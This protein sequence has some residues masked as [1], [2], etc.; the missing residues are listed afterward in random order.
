MLSPFEE[1]TR[2][3]CATH[4]S[5]MASGRCAG[6]AVRPRPRQSTMLLLHEHMGGHEPDA[7]LHGCTKALPPWPGHTQ[8]ARK[9]KAAADERFGGFW[10][11][12]E[13]RTEFY[14]KSS[15]AAKSRRSNTWAGQVAPAQLGQVEPPEGGRGAA[16]GVKAQSGTLAQPRRE[17][18]QVTVAT[19]RVGMKAAVEGD[20]NARQET[21]C[22]PHAFFF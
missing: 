3:K 13:D 16:L 2:P 7:R 22:G 8:K 20:D 10:P 4:I 14:W 21:N 6:I 17:P 18:G 11:T 5:V 9:E 19:Q 12:L 15:C 1:E